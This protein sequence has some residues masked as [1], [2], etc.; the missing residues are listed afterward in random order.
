MDAEIYSS[1][2]KTKEL[3]KNQIKL[4]DSILVPDLQDLKHRIYLEQKAVEQEALTESYIPLL[5]EWD[6]KISTTE[7]E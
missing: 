3:T 7:N 6:S 2:L 5:E 1:K 4:L